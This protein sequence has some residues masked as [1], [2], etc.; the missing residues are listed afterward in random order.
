[1]AKFLKVELIVPLTDD[2]AFLFGENVRDLFNSTE[3]EQAVIEAM[4]YYALKENIK[5]TDTEIIDDSLGS[6]L[7]EILP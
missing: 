2:Q 5:I 1:M 4:R 7:P 3:W 6:V